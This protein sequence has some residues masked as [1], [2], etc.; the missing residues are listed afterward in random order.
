LGGERGL[1]P[2]T[3]VPSGP[4]GHACRP[5]RCHLR[6][7]RQARGAQAWPVLQ[8]SSAW[9]GSRRAQCAERLSSPAA[10]PPSAGGHGRA[11]GA[12]RMPCG[13]LRS[14][15]PCSDQAALG[16]THEKWLLPGHQLTLPA[17]K[18]E[19]AILP[20][21]R[22]ESGV[23]RSR[24]PPGPG[25]LPPLPGRRISTRPGR[26]YAMQSHTSRSPASNHAPMS[27]APSAAINALMGHSASHAARLDDHAAQ[28][29]DH[30]DRFAPPGTSRTRRASQWA[31]RSPTSSP[32]TSQCRRA[33]PR[34]APPRRHPAG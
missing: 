22:T 27:D 8:R 31:R 14:K 34:D 15:C 20:G 9:H 32:A 5:P 29:D 1:S 13:V 28:L 24:T 6:S 19:V 23:P 17:L 33:V 11:R 4:A 25:R 30:E 3:P 16:R 26:E 18:I 10:Q 12:A 2:I 21:R 7:L